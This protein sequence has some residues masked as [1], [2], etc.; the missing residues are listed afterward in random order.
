MTRFVS[1]KSRG[2]VP[3]GSSR[4][5]AAALRFLFTRGYGSSRIWERR[6]GIVPELNGIGKR[7]KRSCTYLN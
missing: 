7:S 3:L 5:A 1:A 4:P 2:S 6:R